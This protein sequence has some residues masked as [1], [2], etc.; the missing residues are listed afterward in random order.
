MLSHAQII[1]RSVSELK[2]YP[3]NAR[4]H[5]KKQIKQIAAS[6]E[7]FGF[8]N[9][10]ADLGRE[11]DH[12]RP[13]PGRGGEAARPPP[14]PTIALSHLTDDERRAYVLADNKLALNAGWD[15]GN[16]GDRAAGAES[17]STSMSSVTGFSLAEVDFVIDEPAKRDPHGSRHARGCR[18]GH[19]AG[20]RLAGRATSG[21]W[22]GTGCCAAMPGMPADF[23]RL[24]DGEQ[25]RPGLHRPALQ[26][27]DRWPCLRPRAGQASRVRVGLGRDEPGAVHGL[28]ERHAWQC[29]A[30]M[31]DGA[32]AFVCMD[33]RHMRRAAGR[34][35]SGVHRAQEPGASGTRP[36]AAWARS[37]APS[38]S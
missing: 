38:T 10:G 35:R 13:R 37:I 25:G 3:R 34:R 21:S 19:A 1:D 14:V 11:R 9:P 36:T 12:R 27:A 33:W 28:P 8:T 16:S 15:R 22:V 2:P 31:R 4:T 17:I 18:A 5:S 24:L 7:R 26:R 20:Q 32:I 23:R 6:I 30:V 29:A